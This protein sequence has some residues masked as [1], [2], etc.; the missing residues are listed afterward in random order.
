MELLDRYGPARI[1]SIHQPIGCVDH[2]GPAEGLA[3]VVAEHCG[4]PVRKLGGRPGSLGSYAGRDRGIPIITLELPGKASRLDE[5]E[6][7]RRY[8]G[9]LLAAIAYP[10][11]AE[12][13]QAG[14]VPRPLRA[15][16]PSCPNAF[17]TSSVHWLP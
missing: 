17:F 11:V 8:G 3:T 5:D 9:A 16:V 1:V 2:D 4:L 12:G 7:W 6:L 14:S 10:E 15:A 13:A